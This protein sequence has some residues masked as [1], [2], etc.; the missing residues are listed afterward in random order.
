MAKAI[1][2][3]IKTEFSTYLAKEDDSGDIVDPLQPIRCSENG[4]EGA[5]EKIES[6]VKLPNSRIKSTPENGAESSSGD[7]STEFNV[8][9]QDELLASVFQ[10]DWQ[11]KTLTQDETDAG[12]T[13]KKILEIGVKKTCWTM[14]KEFKQAPAE[15]Q[16]YTGLQINQLA[17]TCAMDD[18]VKMVWSFMGDN[19][20]RIDTTDITQGHTIGDMLK[21]K[22]LKTTSGALLYGNDFDTLVPL[23][24]ASEF[25]ITLNNNKEATYALFETK[26]IEMADGDLEVSGT[27]DIWRVDN[28]ATGFLNDAIDGKDKCFQ[29]SFERTDGTAKTAYTFQIKAHLDSP[30]NSKDGNKFKVSIPWTMNSVDGIKVIK[31][32][33]TVN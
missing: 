5:V 26:A 18:F 1:I 25:D 20:P 10:N 13:S 4:I 28:T 24:Q 3:K 31:E 21:T 27:L 11:D 2:N 7:I 8:D 30:T 6:E 33:Y 9:E 32:V 29:I 16:K 17:I 22:S 23:R 14:I 19:C 12:M 15:W